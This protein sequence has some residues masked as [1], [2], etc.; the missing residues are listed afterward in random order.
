MANEVTAFIPE[1]RSARVQKLRERMLVSKAIC[2]FEEQAGLTFWDRIH[3][4]VWPDFVVNTYVRNVDVTLQDVIA[5]DEYLDIDRS[6][7][8]S[9]YIDL[10]DSKQSKYD[11]EME[12]VKKA[13]YQIKNEMDAYIFS[14]T[15]GAT[16]SSDAEDAGWTAGVPYTPVPATVVQFIENSKAKLR[17]ADVEDDREWYYVVTPKMIGAIAQTFIASGFNN[18][19]SV[20]KNGFKGDAFGL[21]IYESTNLLHTQVFTAA[22]LANTNTLV[23]AGVTFTFLTT[24]GTTAGN[25]ALGATDTTAVA[26]VAALI[27][28][29]QT[30]TAT[31]V[32]LSAANIVLLKK[33][34]ITATAAAGVL[35]LSGRGSFTGVG[36]VTT[37][38]TGTLVAHTEMGRMGATDMVVQMNPMVQKNKDPKKTGY[39]WIIVDLYG[40]KKFQEGKDRT[41]DAKILG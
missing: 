24:L 23:V 7:E 41:L 37:F 22:T 39:N 14:L 12:A 20:L 33:A 27:N 1:L 11:I 32:A 26:A 40:A 36:T 5:E 16:Y 34:G 6:K 2:S 19:D 8:V 30:T 29:P 17:S 4:P 9:F 28:T 38:P 10:L 13:T 3:R 25:V 21:K 35:T 31:G 15:I 18:A